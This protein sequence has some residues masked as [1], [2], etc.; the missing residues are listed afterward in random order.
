MAKYQDNTVI[1]QN[2]QSKLK[3][4]FY[5]CRF[6]NDLCQ[7]VIFYTQKMHENIKRNALFDQ[8]ICFQ[9]SGI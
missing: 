2:M 6:S 7:K 4:L 3:K 9:T 5:E 1:L 8:L